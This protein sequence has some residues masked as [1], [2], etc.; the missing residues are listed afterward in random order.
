MP[1][2]QLSSVL[3]PAPFGPIS[4]TIGSGL[5]READAAERMDAAE[6]H[7]HV[8]DRKTRHPGDLRPS[9]RSMPHSPCGMNTMTMTSSRPKTRPGASLMPRNSSGTMT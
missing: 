9:R 5:E 7:R 8:F 4:P 3:L 6:I 2:M 1:E